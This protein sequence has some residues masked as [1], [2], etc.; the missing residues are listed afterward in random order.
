[1]STTAPLVVAALAAPLAL[2]ACGGTPAAT[3]T[4]ATATSPATTTT[5]VAPGA[6]GRAYGFAEYAANKAAHGGSLG[7]NLTP[8]QFCEADFIAGTGGYGVPLHAP[9][10]SVYSAEARLWI[11]GC[12]LGWRSAAKG[13]TP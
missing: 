11:A 4:P 9:P 6:A 12:A 7:P 13:M 1:M 3:P 2:A 5:A 8:A 10:G